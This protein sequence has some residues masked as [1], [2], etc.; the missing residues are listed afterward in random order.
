M[1]KPNYQAVGNRVDEFLREGAEATGET[2]VSYPLNI[3]AGVAR[4]MEELAADQLIHASLFYH[5]LALDCHQKS[6]RFGTSNPCLGVRAKRFILQGV[7]NWAVH[8]L[9]S[10]LDTPSLEQGSART[11]LAVGML[12][13]LENHGVPIDAEISHQLVRVPNSL[14]ASLS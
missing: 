12:K 10:W 1:R 13:E 6:E 8:R 5:S 2:V 3:F 14:V 9:Y 7:E 11:Y 4:K